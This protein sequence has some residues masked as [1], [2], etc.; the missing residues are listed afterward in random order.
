MQNIT[1]I[2][3]YNVQKEKKQK[4]EHQ[5]KNEKIKTLIKNELDDIL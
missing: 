2:F 3:F 1:Y 4:C 5:M